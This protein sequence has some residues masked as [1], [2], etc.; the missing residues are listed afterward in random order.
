VLGWLGFMRGVY[1]KPVPRRSL[2]KALEKSI[3]KSLRY[4]ATR[5]ISIRKGLRKPILNC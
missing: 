5:N 1:S 2:R 3:I 4:E